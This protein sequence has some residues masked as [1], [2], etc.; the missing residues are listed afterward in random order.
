MP[1][2]KIK[3]YVLKAYKLFAFKIIGKSSKISV[4]V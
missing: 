2:V 1:I 3:L 4:T